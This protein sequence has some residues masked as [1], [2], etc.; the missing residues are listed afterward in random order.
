MQYRMSIK[1]ICPWIW[2]R[3]VLKNW[4]SFV[5]KLCFSWSVILI[6]MQS[7]YKGSFDYSELPATSR[8]WQNQHLLNESC[9][10]MSH[11]Y[12]N[13]SVAGEGRVQEW[14]EQLSWEENETE[15]CFHFVSLSKT[16]NVWNFKVA[17]LFFWV[18]STRFYIWSLSQVCHACGIK[19][20]THA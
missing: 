17:Y 11:I 15:I 12:R 19:G 13:P 6:T 8:F 10:I 14:C 2:H 4:A 5:F 7:L 16:L 20:L 3:A 9:F 18:L 1:I